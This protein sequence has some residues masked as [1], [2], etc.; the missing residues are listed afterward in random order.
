MKFGRPRGT[1]DFLPSEMKTR[2]L[3][4]DRIRSVFERHG[5]EEMDTPAL[6]LW[7]VLATKGGEEVERQIYKFQD[8]GGRWLGLRFDLTVPLA[9]VMASTPDLPK[10][11]KRH[12]ISKVW[13]YEEPQSGRFR[14]FVQADIDVVGSPRIEADM[15][16]ISTAVEA[17]RALGLEGFEVKVNHRK[18]LEGMVETLGIGNESA[19]GVFHALDRMDKVGKERVAEELENLGIATEKAGKILEFTQFR[20]E[21]AIAFVE[22]KLRESRQ[23]S[24]GI[25]EL[26]RMIE[27]S[28]VFGLGGDMVVDFSLVRGLDYYTGPVF[29]VKTRSMEIGSI[30]G[31]GRYDNLIEKFGGPPTP[32]TGISLGV[33]RLY[34]VLKGDLEAEVL[35]TTKVFVACVNETLIPQAIS[36]GRELVRMGVPSEG[37]LMGRKLGR[38]LEYADSKR[39]PF[40][41]IVGSEEIKT[42]IFKLRDMR[43]KKEH[44]VGLSQV[45]Q[46]VD[47]EGS[48]SQ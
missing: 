20:G 26:R 30:A 23:A 21:E 47:G 32:A 9:R 8:K 22:G 3:I 25:A 40:V 6:E 43:N 5:F 39:I 48:S 2:R 27:L 15:E 31:G 10:P 17:L 24:E 41:L 4:M 7:E 13:R 45:R 37:D 12:C 19:E 42:G 28:D 44:K 33:E 14:E 16:C 11:F 1:R 34:E 46:L 35:P 36:I 29:E 18:I 38:Q